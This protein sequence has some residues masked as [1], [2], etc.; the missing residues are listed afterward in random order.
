MLQELASFIQINQE[1]AHK[2]N[3]VFFFFC[4]PQLY[5]WGSPSWVRFLHYMTIFSIQPLRQSHSIFMDGAWWVC[6]C[7]R[8][9]P[10]QDMNVK[11][12]WV[13]AMECICAKTRLWFIV[14]SERIFGEWSQNPFYSKD[15]IPSTSSTGKILLRGGSK[16]S[17]CIKQDSKPNTLPTELHQSHRQWPWKKVKFTDQNWYQTVHFR[18]KTNW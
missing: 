3:K 18:Y 10:V 8:H 5:L 16:Q 11:I 13:H 12:F 6:F 14:S 4:V 1:L 15:K 17:R 9:S 2:K 7:C